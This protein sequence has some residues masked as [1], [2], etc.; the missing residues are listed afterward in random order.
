MDQHSG[1]KTSKLDIHGMEKY[2][3]CN[4][5]RNGVPFFIFKNVDIKRQ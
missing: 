3:R 4:G 1:Y 2:N 5:K